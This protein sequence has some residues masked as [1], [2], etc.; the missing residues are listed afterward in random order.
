MV[1]SACPEG[2]NMWTAAEFRTFMYP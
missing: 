2:F 1:L